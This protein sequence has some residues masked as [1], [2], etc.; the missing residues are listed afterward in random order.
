[1]S[2]QGSEKRMSAIP[3]MAVLGLMVTGVAGLV[4]AIPTGNGVSLLASAIAFGIV[5]FVSFK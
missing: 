2:E 1:M 5:F 3:G 4:L